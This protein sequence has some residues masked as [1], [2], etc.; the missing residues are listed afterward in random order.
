MWGKSFKI[1]VEY[2]V[3]GVT[4]VCISA[5]SGTHATVNFLENDIRP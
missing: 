1:Q 2:F 4:L 3:K 5:P